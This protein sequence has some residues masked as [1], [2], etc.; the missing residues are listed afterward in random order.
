MRQVGRASC[1][2]ILFWLVGCYDLLLL[3]YCAYAEKERSLAYKKAFSIPF[4]DFD[5]SYTFAKMLR[6]FLLAYVR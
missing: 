5:T 4:L 2:F 3:Q 6:E 1:N